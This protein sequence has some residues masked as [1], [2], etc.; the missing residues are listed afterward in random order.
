ML[1]V[2][3]SLIPGLDWYESVCVCARESRSYNEQWHLV[4]DQVC[5]ISGQM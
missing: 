5:L 1:L 2:S 3:V 4:E